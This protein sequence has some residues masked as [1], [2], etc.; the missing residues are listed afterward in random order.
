MS[1]S[2]SLELKLKLKLDI[3]GIDWNAIATTT[4]NNY[5]RCPLADAPSRSIKGGSGSKSGVGVQN[6]REHKIFPKK[7]RDRRK[8]AFYDAL[9][10][11]SA[12][13]EAKALD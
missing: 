4:W 5:A 10:L 12:G 13:V 9:F 3:D 7:N 1:I 6:E 2:C 8:G 11:C